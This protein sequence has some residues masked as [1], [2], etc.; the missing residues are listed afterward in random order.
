M[1]TLEHRVVAEAKTWI[2]TPY[3][4][5]GRD[6]FGIDCAGLIIKVAH[7][8]GIS[9]YDTSN[10]SRR[11]NPQEFLR[12]LR[13]KMDR[14]PKGE[15]AHGMVGVFREPSHPCHVGIFE[16][17]EDGR[18]FIIHSYAPARKVVREPLTEDRMSRLLMVFRY[19]EAA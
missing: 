9:D 10:Y 19:R 15:L 17:D 14:V 1:S 12:E 11:P 6:R 13:G 3:K 5:L 4:H 8:L 18:L 7:A 2:G 16:R